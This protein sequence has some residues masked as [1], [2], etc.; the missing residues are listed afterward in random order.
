MDLKLIWLAFHVRH[1]NFYYALI[2]QILQDN[3][4]AVADEAEKNKAENQDIIDIM[5]AVITGTQMYLMLT[6]IFQAVAP[7]WATRVRNIVNREQG[8]REKVNKE[9]LLKSMNG[10]IIDK[11]KKASDEAI[12]TQKR[13]IRNIVEKANSEN[14]SGNPLYEAI[15][16]NPRVKNHARI[17]SSINVLAAAN[18]GL[19]EATMQSEYMHTKTW[20]NRMDDR[21][22]DPSGPINVS[23]YTHVDV[24][25][26]T[27][28]IDMPFLGTHGYIMYPGDPDAHMDN[29]AG[30][31]CW[32]VT[33]VVKDKSGKPVPKKMPGIT[34]ITPDRN[35]PPSIDSSGGITIIQPR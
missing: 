12:A 28:P 17:I 9:A 35:L 32:M 5:N 25:G 22:R 29:I 14:I 31:R 26:V 34:V 15:R 13:Q 6:S 33:N 20:F 2:L 11:A 16:N 3:M 19:Y 23:E 8:I 1:E 24:G 27:I 30:C 7:A 10:W 4:N 18:K 21:V